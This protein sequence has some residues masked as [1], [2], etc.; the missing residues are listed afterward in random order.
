MIARA[1]LRGRSAWPYVRFS[2]PDQI[3]GDSIARQTQ[4]GEEVA[5]QLGLILRDPIRDLGISAFRG[6]NRKQGGLKIILQKINEKEIPAGDVLLVEA[7]DRLSR[8]VTMDALEI[9][10]TI[11]RAGVILVTAEDGKIYDVDAINSSEVHSLLAR[12]QQAY[13]ESLRKSEML[14]HV[15]QGK[16]KAALDKGT[17]LSRHCPGWLRLRKGQYVKQE[18]KIEVVNRIFALAAGGLGRDK[19]AALLNREGVPTLGGSIE[20]GAQPRLHA[21]LPSRVGKILSDR[22]VLGFAT[23]SRAEGTKRI[24]KGEARIYPQIVSSELWVAVRDVSA[25]RRKGTGGSYSPTVANMFTRLVF[26]VCGSPLTL[27][28]GG[29]LREEWGQPRLARTE[30]HWHALVCSSAV[31]G[32]GCGH[33]TRFPLRLWERLIVETVSLSPPRL[34]QVQQ[35]EAAT[36][37]QELADL[38]IQIADRQRGV[39]AMARGIGGSETALAALLA[40]S[41]EVDKMRKR[42]DRLAI[43]VEAARPDGDGQE[44]LRDLIEAACEKRDVSARER[45]RSL[46]PTVVERIVTDADG[47]LTVRMRDYQ[48]WEFGPS[49]HTHSQSLLCT[50]EEWED[51]VKYLEPDPEAGTI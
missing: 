23:L 4:R 48:A 31:H 41:A 12:I 34:P 35:A 11:L 15:W 43:E 30:H 18:D 51:W 20:G 32:Q 3:A 39:T 8:E 9:V 49:G 40:V 7:I 2:T 27:R 24:A 37:R 50:E 47:G 6:R 44:Q 10:T 21:W 29:R 19:I 22:R 14:L 13:G 45:V 1:N 46:L 25:A 26:C 28:A 16:H 38:D 36:K 5:Q 33:K 42:R 17:P